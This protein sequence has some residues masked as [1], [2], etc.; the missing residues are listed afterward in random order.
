[1]ISLR[2]FAKINLA[3]EVKGLRTDGY[4]EVHTIYQAIN[5][6]D[7][8]QLEEQPRGIDIVTNCLELPTDSR[9][10]VYRACLRLQESFNINRGV[11]VKIDKKIPLGAGLGGGSSN[12]AVTLMGLTHLWALPLSRVDLYP[13]ARELGADVPYFL[14]GGSCLGMG[15][16]DELYSLADLPRWW[17]VLV[18]SPFSLSTSE[19][20]QRTNLV[21]TKKKNN[22]SMRGF[23]LMESDIEHL[24]VND[25]EEVVFPDYPALRSVKEVLKELGAKGSLMSGSGPTIY[26]L[27]KMH[28]DAQRAQKSLMAMGYRV[29][30]TRTLTIK[31][32]RKGVLFVNHQLIE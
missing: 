12:A 29:I 22:S 21:L 15:R 23:C 9:N 13:I 27:F 26:G 28:K 24:M 19:V 8:M 4:H 11:R 5:L 30:L 20:Y 1:M 14:M 31:D 16:G 3:L 17:I 2:S 10:L 7:I 32:Y 6:Y 25:L 18:V